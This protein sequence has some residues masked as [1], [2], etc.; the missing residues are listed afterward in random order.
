MVVNGKQLSSID[1]VN[2]FARVFDYQTGGLRGKLEHGSAGELIVVVTAF[3]GTHGCTVA[4]ASALDGHSSVKMANHRPAVTTESHPTA[5]SVKQ[6]VLFA[7]V[8]IFIN[9]LMRYLLSSFPVEIPSA[10]FRL[11]GS[12]IAGGPHGWQ[13]SMVPAPHG[14]IGPH[15][16]LAVPDKHLDRSADATAPASS[17]GNN[18]VII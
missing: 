17:G 4:T 13:S 18:Q 7:V 5:F 15:H 10:I 16:S 11:H 6:I 12:T 9:I 8:C 1:I 2:G 14:S 3:E